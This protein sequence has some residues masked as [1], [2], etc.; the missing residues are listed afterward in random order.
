MKIFERI[1]DGRI[2]DIVQLCTNHCGFAAGCG[3]IKAIHTA[4]FLLEKQHEK[5]KPAHIEKKKKKMKKKRKR[6]RRLLFK[7]TM[8]LFN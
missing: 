8:F 3:T 1:V 5:Q 2:R 4:R 7:K 6:K